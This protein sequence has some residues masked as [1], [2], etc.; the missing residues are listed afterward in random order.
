MSKKV[1]II[2]SSPLK[3]G[4]SNTL[5]DEFQKG[6]EMSGNKAEKIFLRD[7]KINFCHSCGYCRANDYNRCSQKDDMNQI[8]EKMLEADVILMATPVYFYAMCGQMKVFIDR[9]CAKYTKISNKEFYFIITAA[10][11]NK[12]ALERTV[13]EF[14]GFLDCLNSPVEKGILYATGVWKKGEVLS[15]EFPQQAFELGSAV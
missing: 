15:T 7:K 9:C 11:N 13:E 14:R 10:D 5:C 4:N 12:A 1:L 3:G 2:S 8:I 6:A